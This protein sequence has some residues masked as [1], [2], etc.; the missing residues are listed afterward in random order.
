MILDLF[1]C[2]ASLGVATISNP[3][4]VVGRL[5]PYVALLLSF[6]AFVLWNGGVVL[7]E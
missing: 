4:R 6:A 2:A 3:R 7:G 5:W 1:W